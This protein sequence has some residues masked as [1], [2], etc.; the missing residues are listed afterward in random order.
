LKLLV[1]VV[2]RDGPRGGPC[3]SWAA[4]WHV[5]RLDR[6]QVQCP[7][8]A[9]ALSVVEP[10]APPLTDPAALGGAAGPAMLALRVVAELRAPHPLVGLRYMV[11]SQLVPVFVVGFTIYFTIIGLLAPNATFLGLPHH[12]PGYG[13]GLSPDKISL[14]PGVNLAATV[15]TDVTTRRAAVSLGYERLLTV[16]C[17]RTAIGA[18]GLPL[19]RS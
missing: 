4:V 13:F 9:A 19:R 17:S 12:V 7:P 6:A 8:A 3:W 14:V 5:D 2:A 1:K 11:R 15:V 18:G 10:G 16:G